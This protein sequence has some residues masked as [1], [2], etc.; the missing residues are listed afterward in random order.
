ML[1]HEQA[2]ELLGALALDAVETDERIHLDEHLAQCPRCR[3]ELDSLL[4]VAAMMGNSVEPLPEGL[5]EKISGR[6]YDVQGEGPQSAPLL[7][8]AALASNVTSIESRRSV[9][10]RKTRGAFA[11]MT[12]VAAAVIIVLAFSLSG[13]NKKVTD[14]QGALGN[15][16]HTAVLAALQV[17]GHRIVNLNNSAN[18]Q[19]VAQFVVLPDGRGYLV[20]STLPTLSSKE[21]YQLWGIIGGQPI[22]IGLMGRSPSQVT[23][24]ASGLANPSVLAVT[25]EPTS[26]SP[27]PTSPVVASGTV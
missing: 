2:N 3:S 1:T 23:F 22:S 12:L 16:A 13:A 24:T 6:L 14:L 17:P 21:S 11:S 19:R 20:S 8:G 27:A 10:S 9:A 26:G 4:N 18:H 15:S 7:V 25:V 5:W